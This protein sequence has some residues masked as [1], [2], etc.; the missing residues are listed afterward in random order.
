MSSI[1]SNPNSLVF[2]AASAASLIAQSQ[3][4]E[5]INILSD[6]FSAI[7]DNLALIATQKEACQSE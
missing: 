6:F 1:C 7:G 4:I 3:S 2:I 5:N